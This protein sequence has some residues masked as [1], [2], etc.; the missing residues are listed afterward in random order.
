MLE[1][2]AVYTRILFHDI[3]LIY[4]NSSEENPMV[5]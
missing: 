4:N 1:A 3:V 2:E 5:S